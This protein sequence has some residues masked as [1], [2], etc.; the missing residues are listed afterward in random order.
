MTD[1]TSTVDV[2]GYKAGTW[3]LDPSHS[4]VTFSGSYVAFRTS[5]RPASRPRRWCSSSGADPAGAGG[6]T[7]AITAAECS[8]PC[9]G[10]RQ[11]ASAVPPPVTASRTASASSGE[12]SSSPVPWR[13]CLA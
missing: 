7:S 9:R 12:S 3:V 6:L 4:E 2:P 10:S 13:T 5:T 8:R 1:S 11:E